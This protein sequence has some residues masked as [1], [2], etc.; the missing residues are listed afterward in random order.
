MM[1]GDAVVN[2]LAFTGGNYLF[3]LLGRSDEAE[4][5][6]KRHDLAI[7]A[8]QRA[9]SEYQHKRRLRLE[10]LNQQLRAEQHSL[11]VFEDVDAAAREY[12][13][14]TGG[15]P[16]ALNRVPDVGAE[17]TLNDYYEP[18]TLQKEYELMFMAGG[19]ALA[20]WAALKFL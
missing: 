10:Y 20:G 14:V 18:S 17:P 13:S 5:E 12:W 19:L 7:E 11:Q 2:A 1:I 15:D 4:Q 8:L 3:S 6:R 9:E 16:E